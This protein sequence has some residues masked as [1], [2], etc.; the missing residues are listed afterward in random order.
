[1]NR[2]LLTALP[3]LLL[4]VA[5]SAFAEKQPQTDKEKFSYS[6]GVQLAQNVIQQAIKIDNES[7]LQGISDMLNRQGLRLSVDEMQ[8]VLVAYRE[9]EIKRQEQAGVTNKEAGEKF[10]AENKKDKDVVE[11]ASGLQYKII[12][13]GE[14]EKPALN[15]TV[16][17][18]YRGTLIDGKEF[19]SSYKRGQPINLPLNNVIKGWQVALPLMPV[20]SKWQLFIPPDLAYGA[21]AAGPDIGPNSTLLFEIELLSI[22]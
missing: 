19:D 9:G 14:G 10:L 13:Q 15:N 4:F 17:V 6:V 22:N 11:L 2:S 20:G 3:A 12:K 18:H 16:T 7:F 5:G 21:N 8:Q 1:M